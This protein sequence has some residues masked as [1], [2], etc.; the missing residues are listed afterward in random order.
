MTNSFFKIKCLK[1]ALIIGNGGANL[2]FIINSI[3]SSLSSD[4]GPILFIIT[5]LFFIPLVL[6]IIYGLRAYEN[7][8]DADSYFALLAISVL[9]NLAY[10]VI[11]YHNIIVSEF[12]SPSIYLL[13]FPVL[14]LVIWFLNAI[15]Y[16]KRDKLISK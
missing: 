1:A 3:D 13:L 14:M 4:R 7:N 12:T 11:F 5:A 9:Y 8:G 10:L 6:L 2:Y 15:A 16:L